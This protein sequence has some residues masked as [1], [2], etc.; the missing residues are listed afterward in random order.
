MN[1]SWH[2]YLY[3]LASARKV[4]P[5]HPEYHRDFDVLVLKLY[6]HW[7]ESEMRRVI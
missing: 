5:S 1:I 6:L 7:E 4:V 2:E 3:L